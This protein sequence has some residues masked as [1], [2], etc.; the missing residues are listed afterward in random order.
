LLHLTTNVHPEVGVGDVV[1]VVVERQHLGAACGMTV[2]TVV[3][4]SLVSAIL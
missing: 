4:A 3:Q 1:D 2:V